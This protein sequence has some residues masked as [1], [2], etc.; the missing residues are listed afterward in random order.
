MP[1]TDVNPW[2]TRSALTGW[3]RRCPLWA[4]AVPFSSMYVTS[5]LLPT[6]RYRPETQPQGR[7]LNPR[8][9]TRLIAMPTHSHC[10][11]RT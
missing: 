2:A 4:Q 8:S 10:N 1:G 9:L 7:V 6:S 11:R 3:L 5:R